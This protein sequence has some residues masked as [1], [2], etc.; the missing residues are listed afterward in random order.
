MHCSRKGKC[1]LR[2][3]SW[4]NW[5]RSGSH[6][7]CCIVSAESPRFEYY[8]FEYREYVP[9]PRVFH[10]SKAF[11][12]G[13]GIPAFPKFPLVRI[14]L[15]ANV[16]SVPLFLT[17]SGSASSEGLSSAFSAEEE[18]A[19]SSQDVPTVVVYLLDPFG[20]G[21][22]SG[23]APAFSSHLGLL[24]CVSE[25]VPLPAPMK[26]NVVFQVSSFHSSTPC[27]TIVS[28]IMLNS[29]YCFGKTAV[30]T[31]LVI[32]VEVITITIT[33]APNAVA[34]AAH[35]TTPEATTTTYSSN[36]NNN[37][38]FSII[39]ALSFITWKFVS[40]EADS[41][42]GF[43]TWADDLAEV[44][45][46]CLARIWW[47]AFRQLWK[48][49]AEVV[50]TCLLTPGQQNW[51]LELRSRASSDCLMLCSVHEFGDGR[52]WFACR[53]CPWSK[54][55]RWTRWRG[56]V[57]RVRRSWRSLSVWRSR[58][59]LA[60]AR[61]WCCVRAAGRWRASVPRPVTRPWS[62]RERWAPAGTLHPPDP[63]RRQ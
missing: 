2:V 34:A 58:C 4:R 63:P 10:G 48:T 37:V 30:F 55:C 36:N 13:C 21:T 40:S 22:T 54:S 18:R 11:S 24:R 17:C 5:P 57:K 6:L 33:I 53:S 14:D 39:I 1:C 62:N 49:C 38:I 32:N 3:F 16:W 44:S 47:W 12:E 46:I 61:R 28:G 20:S 19:Q 42:G 26:I 59:S 27:L 56:R 52:F 45:G 31:I 9:A 35:T 23:A 8:W 25:V 60:V 41:R 43:G 7:F 29:S 15:W 51:T 50:P